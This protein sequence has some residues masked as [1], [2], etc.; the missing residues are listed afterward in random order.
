M[1]VEQDFRKIE[2]V[3]A[4]V[5]VAVV[6]DAQT[7]HAL[8]VSLASPSSVVYADVR[9]ATLC[10]HLNADLLLLRWFLNQ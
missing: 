1:N 4:V 3:V 2:H 5:V 6:L 10:C 8:K 9:L 7:H